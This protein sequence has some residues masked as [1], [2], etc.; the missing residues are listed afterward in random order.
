MNDVIWGDVVRIIDGDTFDV[1]VTHF[2][3]EKNSVSY[4]NRER[5][6]IAGID[7]PEI[8]NIPGLRARNHLENYLLGKHVRLTIRARDTFGRLVCDVAIA[9]K[10]AVWL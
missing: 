4:G 6:R 1:D 5:I 3:I 9:V 7:A 8:P 2:M 10:S